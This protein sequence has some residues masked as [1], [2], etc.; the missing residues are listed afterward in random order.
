MGVLLSQISIVLSGLVAGM[1][2]WSAIGGVPWMR[3][4]PAGEYVRLHQYWSPRFDPLA[5]LMVAGTLACDV[6]LLFLSPTRDSK[7]LLTFLIVALVAIMVVSAT[8]NARLKRTVMDLDPST[9]PADWKQRDPRPAFGRW[10]LV[11]TVIAILV[12]L[13]NVEAMAVWTV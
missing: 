9:L 13:G 10:N 11:R 8:R 5:P 6:A 12:F 4:L 3:R 7:F 1:L 2:L